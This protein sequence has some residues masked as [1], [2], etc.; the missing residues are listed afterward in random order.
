[1]GDLWLWRG[2]FE[3]TNFSS[4][5]SQNGASL[6]WANYWFQVLI[7]VNFYCFDLF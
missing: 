7:N 4:P 3:I 1:M 6:A 5:F 2:G